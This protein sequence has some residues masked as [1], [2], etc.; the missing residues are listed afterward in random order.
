MNKH[1]SNSLSEYNFT[2]DK[3]YAYGFIDGYEVNVYNN[4]MAIGP[5]FMFSTY[6]SQSKKNDFVI[7][8]NSLK[9]QLL[10]VQTYD[11]GVIL[12]IGAMTAG[13]FEKKFKTVLP[14]ILGILNELEAPKSDICPQSG[15]QIDELNSRTIVLPNS[16]IKIRLSNNA[17]STVNS[18]IEQENNN[19]ENAPNNYLKGFG[20]ILIGA[21]V[22]VIIAYIFSLANIITAIA[23]L[24]SILL[25][26]FLYKKFGGKPN[27]T[28]IAM[29]F[30]TTLV[31]L[32]GALTLVYI[33]AAN[34]VTLEAGLNYRGFD[35]LMYCIK[36]SPEFKRYFFADL[37]LNGFFVL[38]AEGFT[39]YRLI[40]SIRR[41]KNIE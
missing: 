10:Q 7:K 22:G 3:N 21:I 23:P 38:L 1:I 34:K 19:Y 27:Y 24:V 18:V 32:L 29:S 39:I 25:G 12:T 41:P 28:M 5:I 11:F 8:M 35:A 20:G 14:Q 16:K 40:L 2:F 31:A 15:E 17:I 4:P 36:N 6:L 30:I 26:I 37:A 9:I 13:T 33:I